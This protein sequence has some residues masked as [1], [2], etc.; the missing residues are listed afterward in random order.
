MAIEIKDLPKLVLAIRW[1]FLG[2]A[3]ICLFAFDLAVIGL[4]FAIV[5]LLFGFAMRFEAFRLWFVGRVTGHGTDVIKGAMVQHRAQAT[6]PPP[7]APIGPLW[8]ARPPD[9]SG[10]LPPDVLVQAV[11][12]AGRPAVLL[13]RHWPPQDPA[14]QN[15]WLGGLPNLPEGMAWPTHPKSGFALHHLMQ[16]DLSE[17]PDLGAAQTLPRHGTMW[18]FADIDEEMC[19][20]RGDGSSRILYHPDSTAGLPHRAAP[21]TLPQVDHPLREM[22]AVSRYRGMRPTVYPRWP[23]TGHIATVW[24]V[25]ELAEG[26]TYGNGYVEAM[27]AQAA[28]A[29][30]DIMGPTVQRPRGSGFGPFG[31]LGTPVE[32]YD[33]NGFPYCGAL[34]K[35][36]VAHLDD[37]V[38]RQIGR[39]Q[40]QVNMAT[41]K[42]REPAAD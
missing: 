21:D 42:G 19:W 35:G 31:D 34:A 28:R 29:R 9:T 39:L 32:K 17:M 18:F 30:A 37:G 3:L 20:E 8:G 27:S 11:E 41:S 4:I 1:G 7:A 12:Q 26:M 14:P 16:I 33:P 6:A 10:H 36:F 5:G 40:M 2:A 23:V 24:D 15:L 13:K 38:N 22:K 25:D